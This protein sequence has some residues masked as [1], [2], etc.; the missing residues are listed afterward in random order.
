MSNEPSHLIVRYL[1]NEATTE[2]Q[3]ELLDWVSA[4]PDHQ[5]LFQQY[6]LAWNREDILTPA[7]NKS[8]SLQSLN[9][10][11]DLI[12]EEVVIHTPPMWLKVAATVSVLAVCSILVWRL[13]LPSDDI[14][15]AEANT[16]PGQRTTIQLSDGS[17]IHLNASSSLR[18]PAR[19]TGGTREVYLRGEAFF[20]ITRDPSKPFIV[21]T[22]KVAT[23]VLGT[24]FNIDADSAAV[25]VTV[26]TGKVKV[27]DQ[28]QQEVLLP[29]EHVEVVRRSG[30]MTRSHVNVN[31]VLAWMNNTLVFD[32]IA[33]GEAAR[34]LERWYGVR[35]MLDN[36]RL[37]HCRI[38]GTYRN[39]SLRHVLE[40]ITFTTGAKF[41]I[42]ANGSVTLSGNGC[43]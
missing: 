41:Q 9:S 24:S 2:E 33:L 5:R 26:A 18:Y 12:E 17:T 28:L 32:N 23:E 16:S 15:Y 31:A 10:R 20:E 14:E 34:K 7:I 6:A 21:H 30:H 8:R 39:E 4:S 11:I 13:L 25:A 37:S 35:V 43:E 19:F 1:S 27:S 36:V 38:T 29:N 40:A 42:S 22:D 3:E